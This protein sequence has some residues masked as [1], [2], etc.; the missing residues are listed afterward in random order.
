MFK[1]I[2]Y[3]ECAKTG[4]VELQTEWILGGRRYSKNTTC[5]DA[6]SASRY[7]ISSKKDWLK[8]AM[9][10]W[11]DHKKIIIEKGQGSANL[12]RI[13]ALKLA[14]NIL[15]QIQDKPLWEICNILILRNPTFR[16]ILPSV[17]NA[18]YE[19]SLQT[20]ELIMS[21]CRENESPLSVKKSA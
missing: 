4:A 3:K 5:P 17:N 12:A 11:V 10:K 19:K 14:V 20:L 1:V 2:S 6:A 13:Q 18:Q 7:V 16:Q 15:I 21:F 8:F 9:E